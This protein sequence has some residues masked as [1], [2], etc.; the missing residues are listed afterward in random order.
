[1]CST[2]NSQ[3]LRAQAG[4]SPTWHSL[5]SVPMISLGGF[6]IN[7]ATLRRAKPELGTE[8]KQSEAPAGLRRTQR[9]LAGCGAD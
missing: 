6:L 2:A 1:M 4:G 3:T 7:P 5:V 8:A 9:C